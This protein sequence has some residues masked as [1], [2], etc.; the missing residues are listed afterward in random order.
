M[1]DGTG[2]CAS[3]EVLIAVQQ[4]AYLINA[5]PGL[6]TS[7]PKR[8]F[9]SSLS[10]PKLLLRERNK[11]SLPLTLGRV[12]GTPFGLLCTERNRPFSRRGLDRVRSVALGVASVSVGRDLL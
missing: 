6:F 5:L 12:F 3:A 9:L 4:P 10:P 1:R 7:S 11:L 2:D 8:A